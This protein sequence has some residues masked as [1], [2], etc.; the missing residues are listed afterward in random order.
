MELLIILLLFFAVIAY[1]MIR[2]AHEEKEKKKRYREDLRKLYGSFSGSVADAAL[3]SRIGKGFLRRGNENALD[4]ITWNDLNM[5]SIFARMD[6]A[7]SSAGEERLYD[8]LRCPALSDGDG[9][10]QEMEQHIEGI[11]ENEEARLDALMLFHELGKS[12]KYAL[13]DSLENIIRLGKQSNAKH[14]ICILFLVVSIAMIFVH[15]PAGIVLLIA[16]AGVNIASYMKEKATAQEYISAFSYIMRVLSCADGIEGLDLGKEFDGYLSDIKEKKDRLK[17]FEKNSKFAMWLNSA[18]GSVVGVILDYV[19]MLTHIDIIEFNKMLGIV[20]QNA[21]DILG[22]S[23]SV[24]YLDAVISIA[25]FRAAFPYYC[26]PTLG[27]EKNGAFVIKDGFHPCVKEPVA[28]SIEQKRGMLITGS[29]ASGKSTFLKMTAINCILAQSIN[30][31]CAK[32]YRGDFYRIYSSMALRD[33]LEGGESYYMVEIKALKR[34]VDAVDEKSDN[35]LM[36]FVDEVLRGTNTV[37]RIAASVQIL[38]K[39]SGEGIY[40]FAATHDIELTTL[41][42]NEYDNYHFEEEVRDGDVFF[43]Y[44]LMQGRSQTRNAIRLLEIIGFSEDIIKAA[45]EMAKQALSV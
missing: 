7:Q 17:G 36:C 22:I 45:D 43:P 32:E 28:N 1:A 38:K 20:Q 16:A 34:I 19:K 41:L 30:T 42:E 21:D 25:Y 23:K 39:L 26:V 8:M 31:C 2:G 40:C 14:Y 44:K 3:V 37:E 13:A 33:N 11:A 24:G 27:K 10:R 18:A 29:N 15:T 4:D 5:D 12:G 6:F 9:K 35:P